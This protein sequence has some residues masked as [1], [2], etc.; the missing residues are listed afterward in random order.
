MSDGL[1]ATH[2]SADEEQY[3]LPP[4]SPPVWSRFVF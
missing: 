4:A 3:F 2:R 1:Q